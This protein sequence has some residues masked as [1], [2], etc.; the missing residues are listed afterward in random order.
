MV[1]TNDQNSMVVIWLLVK[2]NIAQKHFF[3]NIWRLVQLNYRSSQPAL[4]TSLI[5]WLPYFSTSKKWPKLQKIG[6]RNT[7][8][9]PNHSKFR[10]TNTPV[11][12]QSRNNNLICERSRK[13]NPK[14]VCTTTRYKYRYR[15]E[16]IIESRKS[17]FTSSWREKVGQK[18]WLL[19]LSVKYGKK[20]MRNWTTAYSILHKNMIDM[21]LNMTSFRAV[22]FFCR[23][24][25]PGTDNST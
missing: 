3:H 23:L 6:G 25:V 1:R 24:P 7:M 4:R 10:N 5:F 14:N 19:K 13:W 16:N 12:T 9:F 17:A 20:I 11:I 2:L 22:I 21:F 8:R 18:L 15:F